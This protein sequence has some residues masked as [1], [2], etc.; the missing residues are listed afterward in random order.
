MV[1]ITLSELEECVDEPSRPVPEWL[2]SHSQ[3]WRSVVDEPPRP[4]PEWL[5]SHSQNWNT[6]LP[7]CLYKQ[8]PD[9]SRSVDGVYSL[10]TAKVWWS[11][12]FVTV[13]VSIR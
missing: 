11:G 7:V 4:P 2:I 6:D 3:N 1:D 5:M 9:C 10:N 12:G 13:S 8:I